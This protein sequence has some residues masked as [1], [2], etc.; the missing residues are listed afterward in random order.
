MGMNVRD[1]G[2]VCKKGEK[3]FLGVCDLE[4]C[5]DDDDADEM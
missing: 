1:D 2:S 3:T 5:R 4:M